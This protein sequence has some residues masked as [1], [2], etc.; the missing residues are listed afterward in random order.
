MVLD[1]RSWREVMGVLCSAA[2]VGL[3]GCGGGGDGADNNAA[4]GNGS[5]SNA[6]APSGRAGVP[7]NGVPDSVTADPLA[8]VAATTAKFGD[9]EMFPP[10]AVFN[11]PIDDPVR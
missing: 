6:T 5:N 2:L 10:E 1:R 7:S 9:C 11:T 3:S 4:S 8:V